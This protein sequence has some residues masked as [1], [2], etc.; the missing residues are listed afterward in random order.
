MRSALLLSFCVGAFA[1]APAKIIQ[2]APIQFEQTGAQWTARGLGYAFRF[3]PT[4][5]AMRLGDRTLRMTFENSNPNAPFAGLDHSAHPT[6]SFRGQTYQRIENFARLRRTGIY[7]GIDLLYYSR[8]GE[9]EYDFEIAPG[10]DPSPIA[11]SVE[12]ADAARLNDHGDL[13]LTL[14]GKELIER[15]PSVYQRLKS[16]EIVSVNAAYRIGSDGKVRFTLGDYDRSAALVIDPAIAYVAFIG[17]SGGDVGVAVGH[18][19]QGGI[20]IGGYTFSVDF[21]IGGNAFSTTPFGEEDCFLIKINPNASDPTQII[22][23]SSYYGGTSNEVL[24]AMKV[25]AA[26]LIYFTGNTDSTNFPV[27][28]GAYSTVLSAG[29]HAFVAVLD[30]NQNNSY[31]QIYSTYYGG[32]TTVLGVVGSTDSSQGIFVAPNGLIYITGYTTSVDLPLTGASQGTLAG[33]YDAFVAKFDT[34][35]VGTD[36]LIFSTYIGGF[37]QDWG[38][39]V[40]A[41]QNG[42]IYVTGFTFSSDFPYS[43]T[44]YQSY[45]GE[46]DAFL[47]II[48]PGQGVVTYATSFGGGDGFDEGNKMIIDPAG[49]TVVIAGFTLATRLPV[50]Q[51]AY[52]PVMPALTNIDN[53]GNQ[54]GSNGFLAIFNMAQA[55][56]PGQ[57]LS[58]A[59]Y[60]GGFGGEVVYGLRSDAQGRYYICGYTLSQNLPVTSGA[61][62][63]TSAGGGIDGY[64]AVL[65]PA[66]PA[67]N[68][69][70]YSS[71]VTSTGTQTVNDVDVDANGT[72]W[73]TGVTTGNIFPPPYEQ[74]PLS[75]STGLVQSGKQ[76]SF[77]WGFTIN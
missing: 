17:G 54:L 11:L 60:F 36:S 9:L 77:L 13:V 58:Y 30:S 6:N 55:K 51:N 46:G 45:A 74:F 16:G 42:L 48:D 23:Y 69:L 34:T 71:Y 56:G 72:V 39:D 14:A 41:D 20:Y 73:I 40:A 64:V 62:N 61:L 4:G 50:T 22:A 19:A 35:Q 75:P 26:G 33:S 57:G 63:T 52:Q 32:S 38:Q 7:P 12:G 5:T 27:S 49:K 1:A 43:A 66:L 29:T 24:T 59:T 25:T 70:V 76:S 3:E 67:Q 28:S 18:D 68:Q 44:A 15:A 31:S 37:A 10:A 47:A 2:T 21:P 8:N 53:F 65:N